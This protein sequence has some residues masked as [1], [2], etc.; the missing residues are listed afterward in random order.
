[1]KRK[2]KM[3]GVIVKMYRYPIILI[4]VVL[5]ITTSMTLIQHADAHWSL[6][7]RI[8]VVEACWLLGYSSESR[9]FCRYN[10]YFKFEQILER[11]YHQ[12]VPD[13]QGNVVTV[14]YRDTKKHLQLSRLGYREYR[15]KT[16]FN[17][18]GECN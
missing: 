7:K 2:S 8:S 11:K 3:E 4:I 1:M 6:Q 9:T 14:H 12:D 5:L 10:K 13:W 17:D 15:V 18:C 16:V